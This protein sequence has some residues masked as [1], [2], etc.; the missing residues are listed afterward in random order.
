MY[1]ARAAE[2][3]Q[4]FFPTALLT[5][6]VLLSPFQIHFTAL[7]SFSVE[8]LVPPSS[9]LWL[10]VFSIPFY[11]FWKSPFLFCSSPCSIYE[12]LR[13]AMYVL[14]LLWVSK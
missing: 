5:S 2:Q 10:P 6:H 11:S 14:K 3:I 1:G 12:N 7:Y 9:T 4:V 8:H 13:E